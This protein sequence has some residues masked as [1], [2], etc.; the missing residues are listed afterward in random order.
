ML[1]AFLGAPLALLVACSTILGIDDTG[2]DGDAGAADAMEASATDASAR[3]AARADAP[4]LDA[5]SGACGSGLKSCIVCVPAASPATGCSPT[6]CQACRVGAHAAAACV[7]STCGIGACEAP[8]LDCDRNPANGCEINPRRGDP[9]NCGACGKKCAAGLLCQPN[10][11]CATTCDAPATAC[12]GGCVNTSAD[13]QNCLGCDKV[14]PGFGAPNTAVTCSG[15][16][17]ASSCTG[18]FTD[19]NGNAA[20]GCECDPTSTCTSG[21][22]QSCTTFLAR[23]CSTGACCQYSYGAPVC[24]GDLCCI[25]SRSHCENGAW[26]CSGVCTFG[27]CL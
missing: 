27:S 25:P 14:C 2:Y 18:G 21:S 9:D 17:C 4:E 20:D 8:F 26:C 16:G 23:G 6:T 5:S 12:D 3:D 7:G 13:P 19:C 11:G 1:A 24:T 22:C 10:G 15:A